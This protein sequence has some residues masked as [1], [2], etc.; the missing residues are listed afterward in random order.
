VCKSVLVSML[1]MVMAAD[2]IKNVIVRERA[3]KRLF[4]IGNHLAAG[5]RKH[6]FCGDRRLL[7]TLVSLGNADAQ[8]WQPKETAFS[9]SIEFGCGIFR[10]D[11]YFC[12]LHDAESCTVPS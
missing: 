8:D 9:I 4:A 1:V 12:T 5:S 6:G 11:P 2:E 7:N 10:G 3:Q